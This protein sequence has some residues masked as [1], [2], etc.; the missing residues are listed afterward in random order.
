MDRH[1]MCVDGLNGE[2]LRSTLSRM[3][4]NTACG[5]DG[6]RME[7][8]RLPGLLLDRLASIFNVIE[9]SGSWLAA[10]TMGLQPS[11]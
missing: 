1:H 4:S 6:W 8:K 10:L 2:R 5:C 9:E 7:L 3:K 11:P